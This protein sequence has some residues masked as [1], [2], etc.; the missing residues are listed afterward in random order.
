M[1]IGGGRNKG[2]TT[3]LIKMSNKDWVYI[4]CPDRGRARLV[5]NMAEDMDLVIPYPLC[6]DDLPVRGTY[7]EELLVDEIE[8]VVYQIA[9]ANVKH[10]SSSHNFWEMES[11][12]NRGDN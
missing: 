3:E 6:V 10:A 8:A 2:K 4:L 9:R 7:I 5:A 11:L 12:E 1:I